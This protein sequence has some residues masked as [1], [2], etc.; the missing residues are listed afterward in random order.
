V[1]R[2]KVGEP[3]AEHAAQFIHEICAGD[4]YGLDRDS[5]VVH[6]KHAL[7]L[8]PD[9][10]GNLWIEFQLALELSQH[11]DPKHHEGVERG[12]GQAWTEHLIAHYDYKKYYRDTPEGES[13]SLEYMIP[14]AAI[15]ASGY[16]SVFVHDT[17]GARKYADMALD[18]FYWTIQ[19]R[20]AAW[21]NAPRPSTEPS[22]MGLGF[23][24]D[25]HGAAE[26]R[27]RMWEQH[28]A[29][30]A[31]GNV[32]GPYAKAFS[33]AAVGAYV[34]AYREKPGD[35]AKLLVAVM[36]KYPNSP[37][38]AAAAARLGNL[39]AEAHAGAGVATSRQ[40]VVMEATSRNAPFTIMGGGKPF[41]M[42]M[43]WAILAVLGVCALA[44]V[45]IVLKSRGV[46]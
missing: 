8:R 30:A 16:E 34:R 36:A 1:F 38:S 32:M 2:A 42:G 33:D 35:E 27:V 26:G 9:D 12:E 43:V 31:A 44:V 17:D 41:P 21:A 19:K 7:R 45:A 15:W 22:T 24:E 40:T 5:R 46:R 4:D 13:D 25:R 6:L 23:E 3:P 37:L 28:K 29:D 39:A 14:R 18:D 10:P 11:V 20:R